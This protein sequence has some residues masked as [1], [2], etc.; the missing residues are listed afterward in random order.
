VVNVDHPPNGDI[1]VEV[2]RQSRTW[3]PHAPDHVTVNEAAA[4]RELQLVMGRKSHEAANKHQQD[5]PAREMGLLAANR[6]RARIDEP[7]GD[8]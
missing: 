1:I 3:S 6:S 4:L 7:S 8:S 5:C 2:T